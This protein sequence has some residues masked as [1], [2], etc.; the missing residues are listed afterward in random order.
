MTTDLLLRDDGWPALD[1]IRPEHIEPGIRAVL[2]ECETQ[3]E[4]LETSIESGAWTPDTGGYAALVGGIEAIHDAL[5]IPWGAVSQLLAVVN[6]DP[7]RTTY[8]AVQP[9]VVA[10]GTRLGQST[11]LYTAF[12]RLRESDTY[13][14]LGP[15]QRRVLE[16]LRRDAR[17]SGVGLDAVPRERFA[18]IERELAELATRFANQVLDD[19]RRFALT[20]RDPDE[21]DGLPESWRGLTAQAA[22]EAGEEGASAEAG[23]WR[24]TLDAPSLVPFLAHARRRALREQVYRAYVTR[25]SGGESD[26]RP[27][28][29]S[30]LALRREQAALLGYASYAELSV[31]SKMAPDVAAVEGLLEDLRGASRDAAERDLRELA[32]R[33]AADGAPEAQNLKP[34]DLAFWAERLREERFDYSEEEL[35]PYFPLP[36]VL[37]GLFALSERLFGVRIEEADGDAPVYHPDVRFF[38]VF[39][40]GGAPVA[41]FYLDPYARPSEKRGGAWMADCLGRRRL[42]SGVRNPVAFLVCNQTPPVGDAPSLMSFDEVTTLFHEFGHG[43]QHMLT[44]VECG[45][46]AGIQNVEWDAVELPSQFMENWCYHRETVRGISGHVETG[47]PLPDA[48]FDKVC[49]ART[50]RAGSDMLRQIYFGMTDIELHHRYG[51]EGD[52]ADA[53]AVQ[54]RIAERTTVVPPIPE[55]R[56]LCSF[57]HIFGGGYAAGYYSYKWAEVLSADAFAAFEEAGL[58]DADAIAAVGHRFRDTVLA[59]GGSQAPGEVFAA[60]RGRDAS[61][62]AL[63]RHSGLAT[64][65]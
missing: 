22:R 38:R 28:I 59:R 64:E 30:I 41:S 50:F 65:G 10:F 56:F 48:L 27:L 44:A 35:R 24:V 49:A 19:T 20:L 54:R 43:L 52:D 58:G 37:A 1:R 42:E 36:R 55:D 25:A 26:N 16:V 15:E 23:P 17:L 62:D 21:V 31:A 32:D 46:V 6:S 14:T 47:E 29:E 13:E 8:E 53:F 11:A 57:G 9:D 2:A 40:R 39:D 51:R 34:W 12:E 61:P 45:L 7:L 3:L 60:F 18:E 5:E 33:A 63:L 4:A